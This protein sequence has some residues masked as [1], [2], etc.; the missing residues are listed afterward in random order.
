MQKQK[1]NMSRKERGKTEG[2]E[3]E[4]IKDGTKKKVHN[5]VGA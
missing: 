3:K 2:E 1:I 4:K 5:R